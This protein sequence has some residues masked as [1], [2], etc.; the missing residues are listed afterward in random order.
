MLVRPKGTNLV[1]T[2]MMTTTTTTTTMPMV[3]GANHLCQFSISH[4]SSHNSLHKV[5]TIKS[6]QRA[7]GYCENIVCYYIA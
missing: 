7:D 6:L 3:V 5:A 4:Y 1:I 2:M